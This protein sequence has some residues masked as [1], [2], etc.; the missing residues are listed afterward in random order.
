MDLYH[1]LEIYWAGLVSPFQPSKEVSDQLFSQLVKTYNEEGRHY[2]TT[3]H[4][5]KL[6]H[7]ADHYSDI[8]QKKTIVGFSIL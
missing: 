8:I 7:L 6:V 4:I 5:E 2:H 3:E 1:D